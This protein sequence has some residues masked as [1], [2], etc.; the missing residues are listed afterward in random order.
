MPY[1]LTADTIIELTLSLSTSQYASAD[2][3]AATQELP[4]ALLAPGGCAILQSLVVLDKDDQGAAMD[5]V[6]FRSEAAMGAAEN[7]ALAISDANA[8]EILTVVEI[9]AADYIDLINS[10]I[11]CKGPSADG[12][13]VILT[14]TSGQSLYVAAISRG[15]GTYTAAGLVLKIGLLRT[16]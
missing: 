5:I 7:A 16:V 1:I 2:V 14:A 3:L 6:F 4:D 15:T 10:Q 11:A 9:A 8:A 13:G 12:M